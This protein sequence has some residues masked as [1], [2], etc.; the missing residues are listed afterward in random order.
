VIELSCIEHF[1]IIAAVAET[2]YS[3]CSCQ[4]NNIRSRT[5]VLLA[6]AS[7]SLRELECQARFIRR[8][9]EE[10]DNE[11]CKIWEYAREY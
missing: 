8:G 7:A 6:I 9:G 1:G 11:S 5:L 2:D 4:Q 3:N 10:S